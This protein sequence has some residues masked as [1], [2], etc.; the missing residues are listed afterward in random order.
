GPPARLRHRAGEEY[1]ERDATRPADDERQAQL[2]EGECGRDEHAR[3]DSRLPPLR[4]LRVDLRRAILADLVSQP[5]VVRATDEGESEPPEELP[6]QD[7]L[8]GWE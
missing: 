2:H 7:A 6:G 3:N 4:R 5:G 1:A 8:E